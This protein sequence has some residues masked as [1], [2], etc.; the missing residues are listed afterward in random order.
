VQDSQLT[1]ASHHEEQCQMK[2]LKAN[3]MFYCL[4]FYF[5]RVTATPTGGHL[6]DK[7]PPSGPAESQQAIADTPLSWLKAFFQLLG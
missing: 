7:S 3:Y 4:N 1:P 2:A 5:P 6:D